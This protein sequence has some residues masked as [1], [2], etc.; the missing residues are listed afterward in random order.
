MAEQKTLTTNDIL[1]ILRN[2]WGKTEDEKR[3]ARLEGADE[4]EYLQ[5][6]LALAERTKEEPT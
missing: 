5:R 4:I 3:R 1:H 6:R 2:P